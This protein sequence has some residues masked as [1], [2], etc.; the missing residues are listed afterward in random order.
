MGGKG[1]GGGGAIQIAVNDALAI[2]GT[3]DV[4]GCGGAEGRQGRRAAAAAAR[5]APSCSK[6]CT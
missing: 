1:G 6:R 5:A 4:G 2:T 3:I